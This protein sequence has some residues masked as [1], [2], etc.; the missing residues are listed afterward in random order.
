VEDICRFCRELSLHVDGAYPT[1]SQMELALRELFKE[2]D[3]PCVDGICGIG[4]YKRVN[5]ERVFVLRCSP[6]VYGEAGVELDIVE[7]HGTDDT[8]ATKNEKEFHIDNQIV[9]A[10]SLQFLINSQ[11]TVEIAS[12]SYGNQK[13]GQRASR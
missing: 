3:E 1:V 6:N 10:I 11:Y 4:F 13:E 5:W 8:T 9:L 7:T 2:W 12:R